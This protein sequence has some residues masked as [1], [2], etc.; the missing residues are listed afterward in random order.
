MKYWL[1]ILALA[2]MPLSA[3]AQLAGN[4]TLSIDTPRGLQHPKME[5]QQTD[6]GYTG[7]YHSR[8]GPLPMK[9]IQAEGANFSFEL[10][11]TVPIGEI[12]VSYVGTI[13]GD[14]LTG[15]VTNPRGQVPF[16]GVRDQ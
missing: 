11:I 4:W 3:A 5:V 10:T 14:S 15:A 9:N 8:R 6:A 2:L 1:T 12:D 16:S 7:T 13:D